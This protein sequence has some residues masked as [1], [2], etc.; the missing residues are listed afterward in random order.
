MVVITGVQGSGKTCLANSLVNGMKIDGNI[1]DSDLSCS[2][3]QLQ[4]GRSKKKI[5]IVIILL[6]AY[7]IS[8]NCMRNSRKL[9][10]L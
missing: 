1:M 10:K 9:L 2:L 3:N 4:W 7:F 8:Y 5:S 6:M